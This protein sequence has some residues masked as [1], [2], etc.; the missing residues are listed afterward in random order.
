MI[1]HVCE[2]LCSVTK[3]TLCRDILLGKQHSSQ[4]LLVPI[5]EKVAIENLNWCNFYP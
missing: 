3:E 2:M 1:A 4:L 5:S